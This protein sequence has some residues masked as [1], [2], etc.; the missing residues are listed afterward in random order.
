MKTSRQRILEFL[1]LKEVLSAREIA[2]AMHMTAANARHHLRALVDDGVVVNTGQRF[3]PGRGRPEQMY[4]L[5][6]QALAHNLNVLSATLLAKSLRGMDQKER[7]ELMHSLALE[8]AG[9]T[10]PV[11]GTNLGLRLQTAVRKLNG[12]NYQARWEA[13]A[14][15]PRL[16]FGHCPYATV[17]AQFPE[18]CMLDTYLAGELTGTQME[19]IAKLIEIGP[20]LRQCIF[21]V[22]G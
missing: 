21:Q 10:K 18:L 19:Q 8:I 17:L 16:I 2:N 1:E 12:M 11:K 14:R 7:L 20:G 4:Q 22:L 9:E 15:N 3:V 5:A 13:R 6:T